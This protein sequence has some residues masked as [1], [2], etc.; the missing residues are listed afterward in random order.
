MTE[1]KAQVRPAGIKAVAAHAGVSVGTVS[2]VLNRPDAVG[3]ATR[4]RVESAMAEL[5]F[6]R[7]SAAGA[8]RIGRS[9]ALGLVVLDIGNPFFTE[10]AR[11]AEDEVAASG[12]GLLLCSS[13]E[14]PDRQEAHLRFFEEMRVGGVLLSPVAGDS[15]RAKQLRERGTPVVA[16][17]AT[18][19]RGT[20]SVSADDRRGGAL[21]TAHLL[22]TGRRRITWVTGPEG[23]RQAADRAKGVDDAVRESG[24]DPAAVVRTVTLPALQGAAGYAA[25]ADILATCP[26][27]V[28]CANDVVALGVLRGL[29]EAG[30][31][32]P[33]D[34]A[35]VGYD[36]IEF[37]ATAAV[38]LTSMRQPARELGRAAA[39]LLLEELIT[40]ETHR[41]RQV[42][43]TPELVVRRSS[44]DG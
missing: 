37:V 43:F 24:L 32:V 42:V 27:A 21:A 29:L 41:H 20:C 38:P 18:G 17:D 44:D 39:A 11:G 23:I 1:R 34:V 6:V 14:E 9:R 30:V 10:V 28:F 36:D 8:L 22:E 13:H 5:G 26:D 4:A 25:T 3:A 16:V 15:H 19:A 31:D 12:Y 7:N 33:G 40:P 35:L 2:N